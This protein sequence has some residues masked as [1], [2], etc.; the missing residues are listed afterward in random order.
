MTL[1]CHFLKDSTSVFDVLDQS[2]QQELK[3]L[4]SRLKRCSC[5]IVERLAEVTPQR[6]RS[7]TFFVCVDVYQRNDDTTRLRQAICH[8]NMIDCI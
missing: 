1:L 3:C 4:S 2:H 8:K 7:G 5:Y 6:V